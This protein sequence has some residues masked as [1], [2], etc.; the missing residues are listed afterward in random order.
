[1]LYAF[2]VMILLLNCDTTQGLLPEWNDDD[3]KLI[4]QRTV[5]FL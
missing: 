2:T 5:L 1:M 3:D 4:F